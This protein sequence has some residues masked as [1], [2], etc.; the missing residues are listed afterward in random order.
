[1]AI[2]FC[3]A[4]QTFHHTVSAAFDGPCRRA[5]AARRRGGPVPVPVPPQPS[6]CRGYKR[7]GR[8]GAPPAGGP[9]AGLA[10]ARAGG[11]G[12]GPARARPVAAPSGTVIT[13]LCDAKFHFNRGSRTLAQMQNRHPGR[14]HHIKRLPP[15]QCAGGAP[16]P[17]PGLGPGQASG[18]PYP[19]ASFT[20]LSYTRDM[21][22]ISYLEKVLTSYTRDM[23]WISQMQII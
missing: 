8:I 5:R 18:N 13:A 16:P 17:G 2:L 21:T 1:M 15:A 23:T 4:K 9:P 10:G 6:D 14:W 19:F 20:H 7:V 3:R 22:W 11:P 12:P